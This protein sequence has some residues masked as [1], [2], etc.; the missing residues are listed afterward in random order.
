MALFAG[1][2]AGC[3]AGGGSDTT[4]LAGPRPAIADALPVRLKIAV[5]ETF[6]G[7]TACECVNRVAKRDFEPLLRRLRRDHGIEMEFVYL[8]SGV[9][10]VGARVRAGDVDGA[11]AKPWPIL[12]ASRGA[13]RDYRRVADLTGP[14]GR[15]GLTGIVIV[16]KDSPVRSVAEL[17]ERRLAMGQPSAYEKHHGVLAMLKAGGADPA[18]VGRTEF[19]SC[20][21]CLGALLDGKA[22][23]AAVSD[24]AFDADCLVDVAPKTDFRVLGATAPPIPMASL[25]LDMG[26]VPEATAWRLRCAL[27]SLA[28]DPALKESLLGDGFAEPVPWSPAG[29]KPLPEHR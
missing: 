17:Q 28:E 20:L 25:L 10:A 7:K 12:V 23:A 3:A 19:S 21:E 27:L 13:G 26:R 29:L 16:K 22:D 14:D 5:N 15:R 9:E 4:S 2:L 18:R 24:Y 8:P 11:L 6:C 1:L